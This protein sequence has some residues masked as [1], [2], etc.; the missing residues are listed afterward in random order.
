[1]RSKRTSGAAEMAAPAPGAAILPAD[2]PAPPGVVA[3]TTLRHGTGTSRPPFDAFNLGN[4][5]DPAGDDPA[6]VAANRAALVAHAGLPSAPH[7]L[8]QVH[9]TGV[10]PVDAALAAG[11]ATAERARMAAEPEADAAVTVVPGVVLA[12]LTADCL[13]VVLASASGE[14]IGVA[15]AGWRGLAA[16]VLEATVAAFAAPPRELLAWLGPAISQPAFEVGGEVREAFVRD[17]P[18]A[19]GH[20]LENEQGRWHADLY[21]LARRRLERSG[22]LRVFGGGRCTYGEPTAFF[23]YRR[24]GQCGRMATFAYRPL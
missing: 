12:V 7:W 23:S 8:R 20:F 24:D 21:G 19:A 22:V 17:D 13:P 6:T 1:M 2:W 10:L 9:G 16:G 3:F 18:G 14:E 15:H 4:A 11:D 5:R